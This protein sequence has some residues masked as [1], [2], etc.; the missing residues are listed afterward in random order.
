MVDPIRHCDEAP[1]RLQYACDLCKPSI[2]I[3]Y[4]VE[5]PRSDDRVK[6]PVGEWKLLDVTVSSIDSLRPL[7]LDHALRLVDCDHL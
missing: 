2:Q 1:A 6:L 4:V 7:Y 3:G 5:H